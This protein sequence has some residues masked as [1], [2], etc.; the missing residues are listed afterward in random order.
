VKAKMAKNLSN[1]WFRQSQTSLPA[2]KCKTLEIV[3]PTKRRCIDS[4]FKV[5]KPKDQASWLTKGEERRA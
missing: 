1:L 5:I 3:E 2:K 4:A